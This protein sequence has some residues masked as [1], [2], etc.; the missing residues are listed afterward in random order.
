MLL[1]PR[2]NPT[3]KFCVLRL[4]YSADPEK[5]TPEWKEKTKR[6]ISERS[7][8]REY[9]IDY[10][11]FEGKPVFPEFRE[12]WHM[13]SFVFE[14]MPQ[15]FVYR[16]WDFGYHRPAVT[17]GWIN[18]F[19][20][21]IIKREILGHDEGIKEFAARVLNISGAEFPNA[22]WLDACDPAGHQKNDKSEFTS[23]EV[24]GSLGVFPTSKPSNIQ[25]K[26]E[27]LRQRLQMRNDGKV[28]IM[29][30]VGCTRLI[31]GFKGG[32][33]YDE[34]KEGQPAQEE[35]LKDNYYDNVFDS[36]EYLCTNFLELAPTKNLE[37]PQGSENDI[38]RGRGSSINEYF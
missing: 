17:I 12:D 15:K 31:N 5:N 10:D 19:D 32:Y 22:K 36:M 6:G 9:E 25:E 1:K 37:S 3:N 20:Q 30:D 14:P 18:E 16:G 2:W 7:W 4:H 21:L 28:G 27:M 24:L 8:N 38:M 26:L 13:G 35:P 34:Q 23:V 29:I 11:T 33:R